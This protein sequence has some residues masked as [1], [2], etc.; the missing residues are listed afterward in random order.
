MKASKIFFQVLPFPWFD[1]NDASACNLNNGSELS[2]DIWESCAGREKKGENYPYSMKKNCEIQGGTDYH[3]ILKV[4]SM[5]IS[6]DNIFH[7]IEKKL[8]NKI[9]YVV[10]SADF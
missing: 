9:F 8:S 1:R 6:Y 7:F 4:R 5:Y 10:S 3:G 2:G